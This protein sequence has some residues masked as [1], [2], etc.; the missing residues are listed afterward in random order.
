MSLFK[1]GNIWWYEF[2]FANRRVRESGK[3]GS[4]TLARA[5]EQVIGRGR[6][7][8]ARM[9]QTAADDVAFDAGRFV[10]KDGRGS[11]TSLSR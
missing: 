7:L 11:A 1:R 5:A 2:W 4:R 6:A 3:T 9:L 8:A 10:A